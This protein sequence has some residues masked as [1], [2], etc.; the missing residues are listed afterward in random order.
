MRK[1]L[2]VNPANPECGIADMGRRGFLNIKKSTKYKVTFKEILGASNLEMLYSIYKP[3]ILLVN[4][5]RMYFPDLNNFTEKYK[6]KIKTALLYH[7]AGIACHFDSLIFVDTTKQNIP[8]KLVFSMPRPL[9]DFDLKPIVNNEIVRI[10]SYG[11]CNTNKNFDKIAEKV[12][13]EYD[14]AILT[15]FFPR[16][17][18]DYDPSMRQRVISSIKEIV[19]NSGKDI[20]LEINEN[21]IENQA[22]VDFLRSNDINVFLNADR[23]VEQD[24]TLSSSTDFAL[25]ARRPIAVGKTNM[26]THFQGVEPSVFVE[27][28][29]FPE[30]IESGIEPLSKMYE[31]HSPQ[32]YLDK[33]EYIMDHL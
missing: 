1:V 2:F 17:K 25:M 27:D 22:L 16:N 6:N 13:R 30:I 33:F 29:T 3:D 15:Y 11:F 12:C 26:F 31:E 5:S 10:G 28:R 9:N 24:I 8:E 18:F 32:A 23:T 7:D 14:K 19:S 21:F 20:K 4:Y